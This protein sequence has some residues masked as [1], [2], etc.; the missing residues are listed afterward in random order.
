MLFKAQCGQILDL[1]W[2][3]LI[4]GWNSPGLMSQMKEW[5]MEQNRAGPMDQIEP[6]L[7][8]SAHMPDPEPTLASLVV[9]HTQ[10]PLWHPYWWCPPW[11]DWSR[12]HM[13][14]ICWAIWN[15][16]HGCWICCAGGGV[17]DWIYAWSCRHPGVGST[18]GTCPE[19]WMHGWFNVSSM[20]V[21]LRTRGTTWGQGGISLTTCT[22]WVSNLLNSTKTLLLARIGER[23]SN[24][25]MLVLLTVVVAS[26]AGNFI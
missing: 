3:H 13:Q 16:H 12:H 8:P 18:F 7:P 4:Q 2:Y 14:H 1:G 19:P 6:T 11:T 17:P 23:T 20:W 25:L 5:D 10:C 9:H 15:R 21:N 26:S 24:I 22:A